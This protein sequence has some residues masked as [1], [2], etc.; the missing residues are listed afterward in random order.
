MK[1]KISNGN[2]KMGGIKS[3]SLPSGVTCLPG[4]PC[5]KECYANKLERLRPSVRDAYRSNLEL[6]QTDPGTFWRE[7]EGVLMT[8]R[9]FRFHVSGDIPTP[10]YLKKLTEVTA[11]NPHCQVLCF[12][13]RFS[14]VNEYLDKGNILPENLHLVFSGWKGLEMQ[15]PYRLPEAHVMY[16]DGS[17]TARPD[18]KLCPGNCT[19]CART[20]E[21]CWVLKRGEQVVFHKH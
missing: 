15:N 9:F 10:E 3:V 6:L 2:T 13:K 7:I 16:K 5:F 11:R 20:N 8:E 4:C 14:F 19:D 18:A 17:T 12:T 21:G 1:L